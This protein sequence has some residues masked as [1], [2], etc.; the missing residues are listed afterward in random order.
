MHKITFHLLAAIL[1]LT[2]GCVAMD[3]TGN[4]IEGTQGIDVPFGPVSIAGTWKGESNWNSA[5]KDITVMV[6]KPTVDL[7]V[8][9][10]GQAPAQQAEKPVSPTPLAWERVPDE[11][12]SFWGWDIIFKVTEKDFFSV[13]IIFK[14]EG[15]GTLTVVSQSGGSGT[16]RFVS[17]GAER[18]IEVNLKHP[19]FKEIKGRIL[20]NPDRINGS[21]TLFEK[22]GIFKLEKDN[23]KPTE[24][25]E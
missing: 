22:E 3:E 17:D 23:S 5:S 21:F 11:A 15:N 13:Q 10:A 6:R 14:D 8:A 4:N 9:P 16:A 20:C 25:K 24:R 2:A 7:L 12:I 1:F 18:R 19:L